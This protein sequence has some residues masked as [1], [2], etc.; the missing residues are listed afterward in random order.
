MSGPLNCLGKLTL[1]T[2]SQAS[3]LTSL[4]LS[5]LI[6]ISLQGLEILVVEKWNVTSMF[7]NFSHIQRDKFAIL[8]EFT[9]SSFLS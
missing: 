6:H 5:I 2:L 7:K 3:F 8:F 1:L 9:N 4:D